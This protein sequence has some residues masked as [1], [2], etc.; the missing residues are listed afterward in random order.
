MIFMTTDQPPARYYLLDGVRGIAALAVVIF[1]WHTFWFDRDSAPFDVTRMPLSGLIAPLALEGWLAVDLFFSLSGFVFASVYGR[2]ISQRAISGWKYFVGRFSR[3][4]P[5]HL[6]T[7]VTVAVLQA[8]Y[9]ASQQ[10]FFI[11]PI[12]TWKHFLLQLLLV[13]FWIPRTSVFSFNSP[14]WSISVEAFLYLLFYGLCR[15]KLRHPIV[16]AI[17]VV[18]GILVRSQYNYYLG[19]GIISFFLGT[20]AYDLVN[21]SRRSRVTTLA[22][23]LGAMG[24]LLAAPYFPQ[25]LFRRGLESTFQLMVW[26]AVVILLAM[27]RVSSKPVIAACEYLGGISFAIYLWHFPLQLMFGLAELQF[28]WPVDSYYSPWMIS[29]F[30]GLL[31]ILSTASYYGMERP[32]QNWLRRW[33]T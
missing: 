28:G 4:Y 19:R 15:L 20:I 14:M 7:L 8:V 30:F 3:I 31:M 26:P 17:M 18:L 27:P 10:R 2:A 21:C 5:L 16:S 24:L 11:C 13:N 9:Y 1:H 12:N 22:L 29:A 33:L 25:T 32:A 6:V 23:M